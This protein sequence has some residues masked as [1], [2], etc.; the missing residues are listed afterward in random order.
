MKKS[1]LISSIIALTLAIAFLVTGCDGTKTAGATGTASPQ[2]PN[3]YFFSDQSVSGG[4]DLSYINLRD[5]KIDKTQSDTVVSLEFVTGSL[6]MG[7]KE[8]PT[9]GV[10]HY[11]TQWI[12]GVDRLVLNINGLINWD[13]KIY[14]DELKDTPILGIFKQTPVNDTDAMLTKLYI[15]LKDKVSYKIEEKD[16]ILKLYIR[17]MPEEEHSNFYVMLNAFDEFTDGIIKEDEGLLPTLCSDKANVMLISKPFATEAEA[18]AFLD[19]KKKTLLPSLTDKNASIRELKNN[20][21]PEYDKKGALAAYVNANVTRKGGVESPAPVLITNGKLLCWKPDGSAYVFV[22]SFFLGGSDNEETTSYEKIYINKMDT[23]TPTLLTDF[24]YISISKAE[25][26]DDGRYLAFLEQDGNTRSLYI[27]DF[28]SGTSQV[29]AA[30]EAGFGADTADFTWGSGE[31]ANTIFAITGEGETLQLMK[32]TLGG[33]KPVAETLVEDAFTQGTMGYYEGKIYYSQASVDTSEGKVYSFDMATKK[34]S[35]VFAGADIDIDMNRKTGSMAITTDQ[36]LSIYN[37]RTK[38][39][40]TV[41]NSKNLYSTTWSGDGSYLYYTVYK[42]DADV[43]TDDRYILTLNR[44]SLSEKKS[45][46][47]TDIVQGFFLPSDKN[48]EILMVY[49]YV[50][51][52]ENFVPITYRIEIK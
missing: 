20:Q 43:Q 23:N 39:N 10:P 38:K 6:Q 16:N 40:V 24:E 1:K 22:S 48:S 2:A 15:N 5:I 47:I 25:F 29:S 14:E 37:P 51:E 31:Y 34:I 8:E 44:Y 4:A 7:Q 33:E 3:G 50:Q 9:K 35:Q 28:N 21:L 11:A 18:N 12:E 32:Y 19:E 13:Y 42:Y 30:S 26:S 49:I 17:A 27:Y 46:Q 52:D 41:L 45:D 36:G